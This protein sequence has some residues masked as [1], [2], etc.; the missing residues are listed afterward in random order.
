MGKGR[1][2]DDH[3]LVLGMLGFWGSDFG[4]DVRARGRPRSRARYALR[5][6]RRELLGSALRH[7]GPADAP[8]PDRPR[9]GWR[10]G[11]NYPVSLGAVADVDLALPALL[12]TARA[13]D[14]EGASRPGFVP[15]LPRCVTHSGRT[16]AEPRLERRLSARA[17]T[18]SR[19]SACR[20]ARGDDPRHRRRLEQERRRAALQAAG[21]RERSSH[22]AASRRWATGPPPRSASSSRDPRHPVVAL[23]GDGAMSNQL[24]AIVVGG[25]ARHRD[26]LGRDEQ[27]RVRDDRGPSASALRHRLRLRLHR[28]RRRAVLARLR[29]HRPRHAARSACASRPADELA[30]AVREA[31][32]AGRPALIDVP[33]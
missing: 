27:L 15:Q 14:A 17:R 19:G 24:S 12:E 7:A 6:D 11:R 4:N 16:C 33:M 9:S 32:D 23:I 8:D 29:R 30:G 25:R 13:H 10:S 31:L 21:R 28:P 22:P 26:H 1:V 5:G 2:S 18:H 3:P 20:A